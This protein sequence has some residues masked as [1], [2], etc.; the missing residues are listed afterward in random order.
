[1]KILVLGGTGAM[2]IPLVQMLKKS[3][4]EVYVTSRRSIAS[5]GNLHY[6]QGN[7]KDN[8]F[9]TALL[10]QDYD[11]IVDFMI[12]SSKELE[13]RLS[14]LLS[15]TKQYVFFSSCRVYAASDAPITEASPRLLDVCKDLTYLQTDE[16]ALAK[17]RQENLIMANG[18]NNWTIIRPYI[19]YNDQRLQLGV[20]EKEN[21]LYRAIHGRTIVFPKDIAEKKTTLTYGPDVA[22]IVAALI[23]NTK[24]FGQVFHIVNP[25]ATTWEYILQLYL[26]KI[27]QKTGRR[28]KVNLIESS[29]E[30]QKLC[31]PWQIR[32]D[33]LFDRIFDSSKVSLICPGYHYMSMKEGLGKCMENFLDHPVWLGINWNFE[34]WADGQSKEFATLNEMEGIR[35]KAG[36]IRRRLMSRNQEG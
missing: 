29:L 23:G 7:A 11:A 3:G 2:G 33:R 16:Y 31:N 10:Q 25:E 5:D 22:A 30:L 19:T 27:E 21:W 9:L 18:K 35:C 28:P 24:A 1:M 15:H 13:S 20:F 14:S 32:Y 6:I 4:H 8:D 34:A 36:Y 17:A 12:Y 26:D